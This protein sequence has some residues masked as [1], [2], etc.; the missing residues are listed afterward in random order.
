MPLFALP[1]KRDVAL[2]YLDLVIWGDVRGASSY[3]H[4][5]FKKCSSGRNWDGGSWL[6]C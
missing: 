3:L 2:P 4:S 5:T 1:E 6:S